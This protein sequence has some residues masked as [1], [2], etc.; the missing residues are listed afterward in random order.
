VTESIDHQQLK[1][2]A[3]QRLLE[4]GF[5]EDKIIVDKQRITVNLYGQEQNFR[6]D[7]FASNGHKVAI[8]CGNFPK[9]KRPFYEKYF[10]KDHV[11]HMPYPP[12]HGKHIIRDLEANAL[13]GV[14]AKQFMIQTYEKYIYRQF[15]NDPIFNFQELTEENKELFDCDNHRTFREINPDYH[16]KPETK[17]RTIWMNFPDEQIISKKQ[18]KDGIHWGMIYITKRQFMLT[19][20]FLVGENLA[21]HSWTCLTQ[22]MKKFITRLSNCLRTSE[23]LTGTHFGI[24]RLNHLSIKNGTIQS[25][26]LS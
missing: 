17:G 10:G 24:N 22:F 19:F 13:K 9:W 15:K 3:K 6:V 5:S 18:F 25:R 16:D 11:I 23:L 21:K 4:Q 7:V 12:G 1:L 20:F 26:A 14:A 8:G 2:K